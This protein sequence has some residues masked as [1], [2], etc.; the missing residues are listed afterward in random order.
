MVA[1][2]G[3][4]VAKAAGAPLAGAG[5]TIAACLLLLLTGLP[6]GALDIELLKRGRESG[7]RA[8]AVL[9]MVYLGLAAAMLLL[10][11]AAPV[12]AL[13]AFLATAVAHFG[14][15]WGEAEQPFL[16]H[17]TAVAL[18]CAPALGHREELAAVFTA[19]C[20][21]PRAAAVAD[22]MLMLAPVS[23]AIA[24]AATLRLAALGR[25]AQAVATVAILAAMVSL[26]PVI[27]FALFFCAHH[28]PRHLGAAWRGLAQT[29]MTAR[30]LGWTAAGVTGTALGIAAALF[31]LEPR[32][33]LAAQTVAAAFITLSVL[34]VPH[35]ALPAIVTHLI[36]GRSERAQLS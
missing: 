6:H 5:M 16:A 24:T 21:D 12:M 4:L 28:S 14:E 31:A 27:G 15:D 32:V 23:L 30:R 19:L 34:T 11:L 2:A 7:P 36:G 10:W 13:L 33:T 29:R 1:V 8:V 22:F 9:L 20:G 3:L 26:P 17:C 35:M 18:L 25:G